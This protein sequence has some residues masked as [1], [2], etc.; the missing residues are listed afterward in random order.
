[1]SCTLSL[2]VLPGLSL[3]DCFLLWRSFSNRIVILSADGSCEN[4]TAG[5]TIKG[6]N[7]RKEYKLP[8]AV[9]LIYPVKDL[10]N[11]ECSSYRIYENGYELN[12]VRIQKYIKT[13]VRDNPMMA[14]LVYSPIKADLSRFQ[15]WLLITAQCDFL[16]DEWMTFAKKSLDNGRF[17]GYRR[18]R[19]QRE[20]EY[21]P[22][23]HH[24][25]VNK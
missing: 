21:V 7:E 8:E 6:M 23:Q 16:I 4:L 15:S 24:Q 5:L 25:N 13:Y 2:E 12:L 1:V 11:P 19:K 18:L 14:I 20:C 17:L 3:Q 10:T 9:F 22:K